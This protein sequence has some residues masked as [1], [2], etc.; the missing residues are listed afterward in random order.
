[1]CVDCCRF[2]VNHDFERTHYL[3]SQ[4]QGNGGKLQRIWILEKGSDFTWTNWYMWRCSIYVSPNGQIIPFI[5]EVEWCDS[6]MRISCI[7]Q[8]TV[9]C[10]FGLI[11]CN[12]RVSRMNKIT[13]RCMMH[14]IPRKLNQTTQETIRQN[15]HVETTH[16]DELCKRCKLCLDLPDPS[17]SVLF[18]SC[19]PFLVD[20]TGFLIRF[21]RAKTE[22]IPIP[23]AQSTC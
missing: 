20:S 23:G 15:I 7:N 8:S 21:F 18:P 22:K 9:K 12:F 10:C 2:S 5:P 11:V 6:I 16:P 13:S 4:F 3:K 1:M 19:N 14:W 17:H